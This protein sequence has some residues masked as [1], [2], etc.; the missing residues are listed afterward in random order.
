MG[1]GKSMADEKR[2]VRRGISFTK[3]LLDRLDAEDGNRSMVVCQ[4]AELRFAIQDKLEDE[5]EWT[6]KTRE[7]LVEYVIELLENAL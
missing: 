1:C 3:S 4:S 7:E 2:K 6:D 5:G